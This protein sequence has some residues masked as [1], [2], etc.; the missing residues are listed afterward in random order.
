MAR[1]SDKGTH[2]SRDKEWRFARIR[3]EAHGFGLQIVKTNMEKPWGGYVLFSKGSLDGFREAYWTDFLGEYWQKELRKY[4]PRRRPADSRDGKQRMKKAPRSRRGPSLEAKLL[5]IAPGE[6]ISLQSHERRSELWRVLEGP[7]TVTQGRLL[8]VERAEAL[9]RGAAA[10]TS[11]PGGHRAAFDVGASLENLDDR[12]VRP[13][14]TVKI[15]CGFIHRLSAPASSWGVVAEFWHHEDPRRPS[16]EE[17]ITRYD[18][19]YKERV[20]ERAEPQP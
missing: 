14:E 17:D 7:V 6:R 5:L 1:Q 8:T 12:L 4:F 20:G 13:G 11:A 3:A 19:D 16:D 10:A 15:P 18:D 9:A 2:L